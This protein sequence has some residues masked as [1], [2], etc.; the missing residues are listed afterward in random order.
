MGYR[1]GVS[2]IG[3]AVV[4]V[5][6]GASIVVLTWLIGIV[7]LVTGLVVLVH[8]IVARRAHRWYAA[9]TAARSGSAAPSSP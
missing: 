6:P 7:L 1:V 4:L 2:T 9:M 5:Y 3:G 8:G